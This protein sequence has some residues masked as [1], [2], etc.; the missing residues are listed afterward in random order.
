MSSNATP[1]PEEVLSLWLERDLSGEAASLSRA[2]DMDGPIDELGGILGSGRNILL[3]GEPGVG[4]TALVYELVRRLPELDTAPEL[5]AARVVQLS[6]ALRLS[7]L[8]RQNLIFEALAALMDALALLAEKVVP[9][10]RDGDLIYQLA[11]ASQLESF[12]VRLPTS[13]IIEGRPACMN[14]MLEEYE[15]LEQHFVTVPVEEPDVEQ[16]T[17]IV[18]SWA[19]HLS[20]R[21]P[22]RLHDSAVEEAVYLSHRFLARA[23]LPRKAIDLL[24]NTAAGCDKE[25]G[26]DDVIDRFCR[27]HHHAAVVGG[28]E[29]ATR[30]RRARGATARRPP[31]ARRRGGGG[32][33]GDRADQGGAV[34]RAPPVRGVSVRG[35][36]RGRQDPSR[37]DACAGA[38]RIRRPDGTHQHGGLLLAAR[39]RSFVWGP[40]AREPR[41]SSWRADPASRRPAVR[42]GAAR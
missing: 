16:S 11:L 35:A 26:A 36:D 8:K 30:S 21:G 9:F 10:I 31:G 41:E 19:N 1:S 17:R 40:G 39:P 42:R 24:S 20:A 38:V 2:F 13:L 12:C 23:H 6:V 25:V 4:K 14:A 5:R 28:P 34:R 7:R 32:A 22:P 15:A 27:V 18:G 29:S 37:A 3:V 33:V